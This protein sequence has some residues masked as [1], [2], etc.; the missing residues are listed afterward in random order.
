MA[1]TDG[2]KPA[3]ALLA[4]ALVLPGI[5]PPADAQTVPDAGFVQFKYLDYRDWQPGGR[6]MRV[7]NPGFFILKPLSD[8]LV[9]EGSIVYDGMSGAS[10]LYF[11]ALS[12]A[13]SE[14][15]KDY[16]TAGEAKLTKYFDRWSMTAGVAYSHE[17][18]Y[19]SRAGSL[20]VR[21]WTADKNRTL[22]FGLAGAADRIHS[23]NGAAQHERKYVLDYLVGI[24]QVLSPTTIVQSNLTYS[25][26]HGYF[27]DPYKLFDDRPERRRIVAWLNRWNEHFPASD[28]TL[29]LAYRYL[30][31]SFG[32]DSHF[33]EAA[34]VQPLPHG[35]S[36]R[37]SLRYYTQKAAD[38]FYGPPIGNRFVPGQPYTADARLSAFGAWTAG[39]AVAKTFANDWTIDFKI[40]YYEQRSSWRLGGDGSDGI[41]PMAARWIQVGVTRPF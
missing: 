39:I 15:V 21:T 33:L 40:E 20:E 19:I 24:T 22:S 7:D 18:D 13:S 41:L 14:G 37:P 34:W 8:S 9:V 38:F 16:R 17:R 23:E 5:T 31:D 25:R 28:G 30:D 12:G 2:R 3:G 26:G 10:P 35:F 11:N 36:A 32:A 29:Q 4:A 1:A 6:R 27:T